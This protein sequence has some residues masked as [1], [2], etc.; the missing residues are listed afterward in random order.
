MLLC[1]DKYLK[2]GISELLLDLANKK[3][4]AV[5]DKSLIRKRFSVIFTVLSIFYILSLYN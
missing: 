1:A 5:A 2:T 4:V 3:P